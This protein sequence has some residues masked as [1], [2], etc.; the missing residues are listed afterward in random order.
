MKIAFE[1]CKKGMTIVELFLEALI[2]AYREIYGETQKQL[3]LKE[4]K[5]DFSKSFE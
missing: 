5:K 4:I 1:A 3:T 2:K